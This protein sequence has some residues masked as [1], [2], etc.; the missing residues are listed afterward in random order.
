[1]RANLEDQAAHVQHLLTH[2]RTRLTAWQQEL[3]TI[4]HLSPD[5]ITSAKVCTPICLGNQTR[6]MGCKMVYRQLRR[7]NGNCSSTLLTN[8]F[9]LTSFVL[10]VADGAS[11]A[12]GLHGC[13]GSGEHIERGR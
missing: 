9:L 11:G 3:H 10:C 1:M 7:I 6:P 2:A 12:Q 4:G 13:A 8:R 5:S